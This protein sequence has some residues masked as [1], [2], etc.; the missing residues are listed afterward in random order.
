MPWVFGHLWSLSIEEQFYLIWPIAMLSSF[1]LARR[2]AFTAIALAPLFRHAI[3]KLGFPLAAVYCFPSVADSLAAGCIL[4]LFQPQ[5]KKYRA[6]FTWRGFSLI[7][8]V[9]LCIPI[10]HYFCHLLRFW[11]LP[12]LVQILS[13]PIFN[14]A[15]ILGI[16]NAIIVRYRLLNT[17]VIAWIGTLS[18]SLY[19]W[20]MPFANPTVQSWA[21]MFPQNFILAL[22]AA[23]V[24][25]YA[26]EQPVLRFRGRRAKH[27]IPSDILA[28]V[29]R[30]KQF[31]DV[32][33][34]NVQ[35]K[36]DVGFA[37]YSGDGLK[38]LKKGV[39]DQVE[40]VE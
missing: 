13:Y 32:Q 11:P 30:G 26:I 35:T 19:I 5:L 4:A 23:I 33:T 27:R 37:T 31:E 2:F 9:M 1:V 21:T 7:W 16:Q 40:G 10:A 12:Q 34:L 3:S 24:S 39:K 8:I 29:E 28:A 14:L 15:A 22:L 18:Y 36:E 20:Q 6:F 38:A 25:F 17:P